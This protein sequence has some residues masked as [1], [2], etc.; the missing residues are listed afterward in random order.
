M[1]VPSALAPHLRPFAKYAATGMFS[2]GLGIV[3]TFLFTE[4]AGF[5]PRIS[6]GC[7]LAVLVL[8]NFLIGRHIIFDAAGH[9]AGGQF[10]RFIAT[11]GTAPLLEWS[12]FNLLVSQTGVHYL[13]AVV[14]VLGTSFCVK[15]FVYRRLVFGKTA[16]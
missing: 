2:G 3:L 5:D 15:Y 7:T 1:R 16:S 9:R 4:V 8:V 10:L 11:S 12:L 13:L 14:G 6:Y